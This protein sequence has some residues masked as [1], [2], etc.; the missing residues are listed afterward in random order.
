MDPSDEH[1]RL[2]DELV[3]NLEARR[4]DR[5]AMARLKRCAGRALA[6][7]TDVF[8]LFYGLLPAVAR[9][10]DWLEE[11]CFLIATLFPLAPDRHTGDLGQSLRQLAQQMSRHADG[12]ERRLG[13]LLDCATEALPFRLRQTVGFLAGRGVGV[14]WRQ[15]LVDILQWEWSSRPAQK[16]WARSYFGTPEA[17]EPAARPHDLAAEGTRPIAPA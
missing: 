8:P 15:L 2:A 13:V 10:K 9:G 17:A 6:E 11:P 7:C 14:D 3:A 1:I 5:A 16:R 12:V 4:G